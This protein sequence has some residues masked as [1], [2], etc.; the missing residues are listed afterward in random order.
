V[1]LRL[2]EARRAELVARL[3]GYYLSEFDEKLSAFRAAQLL[4]FMLG[5]LGPP[6]YNQG[7]Q[8]ARGFMLRKLDDLDGEVYAP[9]VG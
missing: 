2:G 9:D 1:T 5:A 8:D 4:D 6:V 7:V 3:Q